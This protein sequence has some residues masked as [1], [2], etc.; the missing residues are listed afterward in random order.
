MK[1]NSHDAHAK[2]AKS[3]PMHMKQY[4][5][6]AIAGRVRGSQLRGQDDAGENS[7]AEEAQESPEQEAQEEMMAVNNA[8][9]NME[10]PSEAPETPDIVAQEKKALSQ[11]GQMIKKGGQ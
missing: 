4:T 9:N 10:E 6:A 2:A 1:G 11:H 5:K 8:R 7:A 3:L